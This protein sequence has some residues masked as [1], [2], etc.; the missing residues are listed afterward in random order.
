MIKGS[1]EPVNMAQTETILNQ[2]K[3]CICK[4]IIRNTSG[5][6]FFC[7]I[8][9][10]KK[11][12]LFTNYHII[13]ENYIKENKEINILLNDNNETKKLDLN[14]KRILYYNKEY[15]TTIIE[16]KE[17]DKIKEYLELDDKLFKDNEN[18][19]YQGKSIYI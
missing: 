11:N 18:L 15:D 4:I 7:L 16:L 19:I 12:F 1:V 14:I 3:N 8:P 6:G 9:E 17:E 10:L 13:N 2:M 5:T